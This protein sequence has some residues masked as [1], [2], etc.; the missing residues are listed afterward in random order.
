[1]MRAME[2]TTTSRRRRRRTAKTAVPVVEDGPASP[3]PIA[4]PAVEPEPSLA[5]VTPEP[6]FV[7]RV[8]P[9]APERLR[10]ATRHA[11]F[12][13][14]ENT[15]NPAHIERV[16]GRLA[17]DHI[18]RSTEFFA[19]GNWRVIGHETGRVLAR[20]GAQLLHSAPST[21]VRDWSDLRIAVSAGVWLAGARPGDV[22]EIVSDDRA[23]DAVGDVAAALGITF[24]RLS[25]R[26]LT[27][28][29]PAEASRPAPAGDRGRR[30]GRGGRRGGRPGGAESEP[31]RTEA[32]RH[33]PAPALAESDEGHS[34]PHDE[35][36]LVVRELADRSPNG[37]VLI[38]NVARTLKA[39][40]F[41]RPPGS[42]RLV[43]RL[44]R[45]KELSVSP[46]GMISLVP[47]AVVRPETPP[48]APPVEALAEVETAPAE[49]PAPAPA[50]P[51]RGRR[52]SRR[53][54]RGRRRSSPA[55]G[56]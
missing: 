52:R 55:A 15:S 41:S 34:A 16:V 5:L 19:V 54:G 18:G 4:P 21:G 6:V 8:P 45:I 37:A 25:A 10:P 9:P 24:H 2:R 53:G 26:T 17:I 23:F 14:V 27:G 1:M 7:T 39:R 32:V 33:A 3:P 48:P 29:P 28:A 38:D 35:L 36:V 11:I 50:A 47:D 30:R 43:T 42:P 46:T 13:D 49:I 12:F 20:Y 22:L 40:G 31:R 56:T 51:S 44:R